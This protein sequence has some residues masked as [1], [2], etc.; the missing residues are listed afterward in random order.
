MTTDDD[1]ERDTRSGGGDVM[2]WIE[3]HADY[4]DDASDLSRR[5]RSVQ[6][7][8]AAFLDDRPGAR[9]QVVSAC[10]GDGRDVLEVLARRE[11]AARVSVVL[12]ETHPE[13]AAAA[14]EL[15]R[16]NGLASVEVRR[17]DAGVTDSYRG[18]VPADLVMFCGVFGNLSDEDVHGTISL[19]PQFCASGASVLWT[20][21]RFTSGDLTPMIRSRFAECG[22][23]EI[24]FDA[25]TDTKYR[26]GHHRFTGRPEPLITGHTFFT[27]NR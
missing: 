11:D 10:A 22:F 23:D 19:F 20:R 14:V 15:A 17:L 16:R 6:R 25:P 4:A 9:L 3:W 5:R 24:A 26:V 27:F 18:A 1:R 13:L 8:I 21:G 7:Q 2:D 12:I